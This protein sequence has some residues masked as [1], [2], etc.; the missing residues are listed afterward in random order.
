MAK[1]YIMSVL[2][3]FVL[4]F[5]SIC[6]VFPNW[7]SDWSFRKAI[8]NNLAIGGD[9]T[10]FPLLVVISNDADLNSYASNNGY[11]ILF[12]LSNGQNKLDHEIEYYS[13]GTLIA[14]VKIPYFSASVQS[15]NNLFMYFDKNKSGNQQNISGVWS[16]H[17]AVFHLSSLNDSTAIAN[18]L[19]ST[20]PSYSSGGLINDNYQFANSG[21]LACAALNN[22]N[23]PQT[24][25]TISLW[26]KGDFASQDETV[27]VFDKRDNNRSH[28]YMRCY[29]A[30]TVQLCFQTNAA[31]AHS[32]S[33]GFLNNEWNYF[34]ITYSTTQITHYSNNG[35]FIS[36]AALATPNQPSNQYFD[37]G[38][39]FTGYIDE[40]RLSSIVRSSNWI[41]NEYS[42]QITPTACRKIGSVETFPGVI[43]SSITPASTPC[44]VGD[45]TVLTLDARVLTNT[46]TSVYITWG[47]GSSSSYSPNMVN[48]SAENFSYVFNTCSNFTVTA[49]VSASNGYVA[50]NSTTIFT[51]PYRFF[52]PQHMIFFNDSKG[53]LVKWDILS[54]ANIMHFNLYRGNDL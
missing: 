15:S 42:N 37:I 4:L 29:T 28:Y 45:N 48:I 23:F 8:T 16:G 34:V 39:A 22:L 6:A 49:V 17:Q 27:G 41:L 30:T 26:A 31:Y 50:T 3:I 52:N 5:F 19:A 33:R 13:A 40:V 9:L 10:N 32:A 43:F 2:K 21:K 25:G 35:Y 1:L 20:G 7:Y 12:T 24:A 46:I 44:V 11:D 14:W 53:C 18:V 47:D 54:S 36:T 51:L 38:N